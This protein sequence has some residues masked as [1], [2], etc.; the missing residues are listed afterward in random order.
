MPERTA[1][2][3]L[4]ERPHADVFD[5]RRPRTVRLALDAGE[6]V[7]PHTHPGLD[8]VLHLLSGRLEL[9]LDG[10]TY[11]LSAGELIRFSGDR[12]VSPHAV[13]ESVAVV[14]FAPAEA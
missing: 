9:A 1:L 6:R 13:D 14:V 7:P 12:E 2:D 3:E 11:D 8:I 4:T 5:T 10:E